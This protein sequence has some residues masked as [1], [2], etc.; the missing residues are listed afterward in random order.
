MKRQQEILQGV[1]LV[2]LQKKEEIALSLGSERVR[3]FLTE[4]AYVA[5]KP[6]APRKLF[7]AIFM[8]LF[9]MVVP[10]VCLYGKKQL[11]DLIEEYKK[12]EY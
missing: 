12:S 11:K 9:T 4:P 5:S 7:A 8:V 10:V 6:V 1:Y 3:G 2:L